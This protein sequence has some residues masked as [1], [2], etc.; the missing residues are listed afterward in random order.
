MR[1]AGSARPDAISA[2]RTRSLRLGHGLVGQ[3]DDVEGGQAGRDLDLHVDGA[4]L[5][6]LERHGGD[7]LD[8]DCPCDRRLEPSAV[9]QW[10]LQEH[11]GN[12]DGQQAVGASTAPLCFDPV[13][14]HRRHSGPPKFLMARMPVGEVTLISV[15]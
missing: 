9:G 11:L 4:G 2:A 3:A 6:A 15:R 1:R 5:D 8:H 10:R 7:A 13:P 14:D 12:K